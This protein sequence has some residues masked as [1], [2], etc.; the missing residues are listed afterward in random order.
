MSKNKQI[1][2]LGEDFAKDFYLKEG[3]QFVD[4]NWQKRCGEIDLICEKDGELVFIEVKTRTSQAF[5][6]GEESVTRTKKQ[7]ISKTIDTFLLENI[8]FEKHFPRFD[9]LTVE[10]FGLV[11]KFIQFENVCLYE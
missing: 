1:G 3:Y 10:L 5:G 4:K 8:Q 7:K 11:P 9:I 2:R 6:Y